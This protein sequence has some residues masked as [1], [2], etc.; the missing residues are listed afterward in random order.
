MGQEGSKHSKPP[1]Y[2]CFFFGGGDGYA[3]Y[4]TRM[5]PLLVDGNLEVSL[6]NG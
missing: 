4:Y 6:F 1:G 5:A 3:V 2:I